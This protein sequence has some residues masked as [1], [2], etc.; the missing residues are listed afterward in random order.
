MDG[1]APLNLD[2]ASHDM[3]QTCHRLCCCCNQRERCLALNTTKT[4]GKA[5][6][7]TTNKLDQ[8]MITFRLALYV[9][10]SH[11]ACPGGPH[12]AEVEGK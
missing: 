11:V 5:K 6:G 10:A 12:P 8:G 1:A 4:P 2:N 3:R 9:R 7:M